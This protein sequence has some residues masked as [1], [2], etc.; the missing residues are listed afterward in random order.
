MF[1]KTKEQRIKKQ[2]ATEA[3][4]LWMCVVKDQIKDDLQI[5][6]I[7]KKIWYAL[8]V[9]TYANI[10]YVNMVVRSQPTS[11]VYFLFFF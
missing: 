8:K 5:E 6:I 2:E 11:I 1:N 3:F 4:K 10:E 7:K 9:K